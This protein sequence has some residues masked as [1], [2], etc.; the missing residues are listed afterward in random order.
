MVSF[1]GFFEHFFV[2]LEFFFGFKS[3]AVDSCELWIVFVSSPVGTGQFG[4]FEDAY[5]SGGFEVWSGAEVSVKWF[6][7]VSKIVE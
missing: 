5:F 4:E 2:G 1:F 7:F 6:C 3:D